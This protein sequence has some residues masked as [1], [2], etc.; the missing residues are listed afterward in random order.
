MN[1]LLVATLTSPLVGGPPP[2]TARQWRAVMPIVESA[3]DAVAFAQA[4]ERCLAQEERS[5]V[6]ARLDLV[7]QYASAL[8]QLSESGIRAVTWLDERYPARLVDRLGSNA[9]PLL[10]MAGSLDLFAQPALGVVGSRDVDDEASRFAEEAA[11]I[12]AERGLAI[13][14]GGARGIDSIAMLAALREGGSSVAYMADSLARGAKSAALR[15]A[16]ED[17]R[18]GLASPFIPTAGFNVGNAMARNK[19]IYAHSE[20]TLV[21][22][23]KEGE[24]GT[25]AGAVEALQKGLHP[26]LVRADGS[27]GAE[28]LVRKGA[29]AVHTVEEIWHAIAGYQPAQA[30][31]EL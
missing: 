19:L 27:P 9:P 4:A 10:Y 28:A 20:A 13:V 23:V 11:R 1:P 21:A 18:V 5:A 25:W 2:L 7:D 24:G 15:D 16:M 22:A 30:T 3:S 17:G 6:L 31:F 12:A 14:S 29:V 8:D 26:V